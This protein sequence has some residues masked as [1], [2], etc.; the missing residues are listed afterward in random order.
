MLEAGGQGGRTPPQILADQKAPHYYSP[1]PDF[2]TLRHACKM[3]CIAPQNHV[4]WVKIV[5]KGV[6]VNLFQ[7]H[8]FL[9]KLDDFEMLTMV[10]S[11]VAKKHFKYFFLNQ[12][13]ALIEMCYSL[14]YL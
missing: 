5:S 11:K 4:K 8:L 3:V 9:E 14:R 2:Q 7:K 6:Q 13:L 1:P 12:W 10:A